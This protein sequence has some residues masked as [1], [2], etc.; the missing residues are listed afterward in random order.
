MAYNNFTRLDAQSAAKK[1][2]S[3]IGLGYYLCS[4][5]RFSACKTTPDGSRL[6]EIVPTRNRD[7]VFPG[8]IV[9]NNVSSSIKCDK[10][11]RTRLRSDILSFNQMSEKFNQDMCLSGKIPSGMFNNMFAFSKCWPKDAS[12]VKNLAYWFISLYIRVEIVRKQLTLRDEVKRE[13]PS[14]WYSC[15]C[16]SEY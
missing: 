1:A 15:S 5:V 7:L 12:S 10:G 8:G 16:W 3:V 14:S 6:V 11:K 4:D 9:V 2:V 13:V